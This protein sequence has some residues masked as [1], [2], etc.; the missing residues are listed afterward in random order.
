M[1]RPPEPTGPPSPIEDEFDDIPLH[2]KRPFGSGLYKKAITFVPASSSLKT[3]NDAPATSGNS[4]ADLYLSMV[5]PPPSPTKVTLEDKPPPNQETTEEPSPSS[6]PLCC[7]SC[8]LPLGPDH[9]KSLAHQL[10]LPHS[11]P[12]SALDRSRMGL[13]YLSSQGWDPDSRRGLGSGQQG[14][15]HPI[16]PKPK[17]DRLGLGV[18]IPKHLKGKSSPPKEKLL[19]AKKVRKQYEQ[20]KKK[21]ERVM[22]ELHGDGKWEKYLGSGAG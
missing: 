14:I 3:V 1:P 2:Q 12:P 6:P 4:I 22:K 11:H 9:E 19:D 15:Q 13:Q 16:K 10:S 8:L 20:E 5:L 18:E 7:P 21:K 17:D